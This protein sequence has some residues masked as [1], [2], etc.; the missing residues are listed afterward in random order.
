MFKNVVGSIRTT[1]VVELL[2]AKT[3]MPFAEHT[4]LNPL[5]S[6]LDLRFGRFLRVEEGIECLRSLTSRRILRSTY[7]FRSTLIECQ[8]KHDY[9]IDKRLTCV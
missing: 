9:E 7:R 3:I 5:R 1:L 8:R 6:F 4:G 2:V